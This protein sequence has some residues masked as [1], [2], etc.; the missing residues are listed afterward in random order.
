[1]PLGMMRPVRAV[2]FHAD[3]TTTYGPSM[4]L[5]TRFLSSTRGRLAVT[6]LAVGAL[7]LM[8]W[9]PAPGLTLENA[10]YYGFPVHPV[11][12]G[13]IG[14]IPFLGAFLLIE[15]A[16]FVVPGWSTLPEDESGQLAT[17]QTAGWLG[18][19]IAGAAAV[20]LDY[21]WFEWLPA[22]YDPFYEPASMGVASRV[23]FGASLV[24]ASAL[25]YVLARAISL[26]GIGNGF[27]VLFGAGLSWELIPASRGFIDWL[28]SMNMQNLDVFGVL[29]NS[30]AAALVILGTLWML[31]R[32]PYR[33]TQGA[34]TS[35]AGMDDPRAWPLPGPTSSILPLAAAVLIVDGLRWLGTMLH[36][37]GAAEVTRLAGRDLMPSVETLSLGS[38]L[39]F[40][41]AKI[42]V[43]GLVAF[44]LTRFFIPIDAMAD[45]WADAAGPRADIDRDTL[46][47]HLKTR[48]WKA[49]LIAAGFLVGV[50]LLDAFGGELIR[51]LGATRLVILTAIGLDLVGEFRFHKSHGP[52]VRSSTV[53]RPWALP[54]QS[55]RERGPRFA[56]SRYFR[57]LY[58]AFAPFAPIEYLQPASESD[59]P[60]TEDSAAGD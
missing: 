3:S 49:T 7:L 43:V 36:L 30:L 41:L 26:H 16:R 37:D 29:G 8:Q 13:A 58:H 38:A 5:M 6:G 10:A 2:P 23:L 15:V 44:G 25:S 55:A 17:V 28:R 14:V 60:E 24:G 22:V 52:L 45:R 40:V 42:A 19:L 21:Y 27:V 35:A 39:P 1:M 34:D 18:V 50:L 53:Q 11:T 31:V 56:R 9:L 47:D 4:N 54:A 12:M 20:G 57:T 51:S 59:L 46:V 48:R 33:G 32:A